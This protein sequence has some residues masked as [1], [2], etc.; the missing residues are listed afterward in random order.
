MGK[1]AVDALTAVRDTRF[2]AAVRKVRRVGEE[3]QHLACLVFGDAQ[4][5]GRD[6]DALA[7]TSAW[8]DVVAAISDPGERAEFAPRI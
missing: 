1:W 2:W 8:S 4:R 5:I 7:E 6:L 3:P